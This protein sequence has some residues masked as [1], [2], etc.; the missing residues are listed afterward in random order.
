MEEP[1][2]NVQ[3][4]GYQFVKDGIALNFVADVEKGLV[5]LKG[6]TGDMSLN[7][8]ETKVLI[9]TLQNLLDLVI[10]NYTKNVETEEKIDQET[11]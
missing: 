11:R 9:Q 1:N 10:V 6:K 5:V 2:V 3:N 4:T 7:I 8:S